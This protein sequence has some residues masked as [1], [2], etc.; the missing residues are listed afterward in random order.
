MLGG[1]VQ[2]DGWLRSTAFARRDGESV[3]LKVPVEDAQA[4]AAGLKRTAAERR[5]LE[6]LR[7]LAD[8][9]RVERDARKASSATRGDVEA[10]IGRGVIERRISGPKSPEPAE[11]KPAPT[12]TDDQRRAADAIEAALA[13]ARAARG[14]PRRAERARARFCCAA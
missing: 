7:V 5:Q 2:L 8:G 10:L 1:P 4:A 6:L 14:Q 3:A 11:P 9:E 13:D 12:L